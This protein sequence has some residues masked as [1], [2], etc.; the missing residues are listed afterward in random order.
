MSD[1]ADSETLAVQ[2]RPGDF[3]VRVSDAEGEREYT[4]TITPMRGLAARVARE[5]P[6]PTGS[7]A[8]ALSMPSYRQQTRGPRSRRRRATRNHSPPRRTDGD[9]DADPERPPLEL[10]ASLALLNAV[11]SESLDRGDMEA[12]EDA[13]AAA[14]AEQFVYHW[15]R[16]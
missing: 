4:G 15:R 14:W 7:S 13:A 5:L 8:P 9:D 2:V 11:C 10:A 3:K 16:A 1:V 12:A 6:S